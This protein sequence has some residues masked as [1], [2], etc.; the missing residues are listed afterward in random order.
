MTSVVQK[1]LFRLG[2]V[3]AAMVVVQ[4][5]VLGGFE[6]EERAVTEAGGEGDL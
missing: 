4:E 6:V 5:V 1:G 2:G 3:E